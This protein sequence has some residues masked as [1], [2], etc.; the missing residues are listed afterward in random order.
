MLISIK[1]FVAE[2]NSYVGVYIFSIPVWLDWRY[3]ISRFYVIITKSVNIF[4]NNDFLM[5]LSEFTMNYTSATRDLGK[6]LLQ[7]CLKP[8]QCKFKM[9]EKSNKIFCFSV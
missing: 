3:S 9:I 5:K 4:L 6:N 2:E 7:L 8:N 1:V